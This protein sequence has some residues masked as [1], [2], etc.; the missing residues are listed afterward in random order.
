VHQRI[1]PSILTSIY[2]ITEASE[3]GN[4]TY[5]TTPIA[6]PI[7][8]VRELAIKYEE[9][10]AA[11]RAELMRHTLRAPFICLHF[12]LAFNLQIFEG[13]GHVEVA[14]GGAEGAVAVGDRIFVRRRHF[15][16]IGDS[17]AVAAAFVFGA[18]GR[19]VMQI[20]LHGRC[21]IFWLGK[22]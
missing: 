9:V 22:E 17:T 5:V 21:M 19:G 15:D 1:I 2:D 16:L 14:P 13:E 7:K 3:L 20:G 8:S 10:G 12:L 6:S 4:D 18:G 11:S